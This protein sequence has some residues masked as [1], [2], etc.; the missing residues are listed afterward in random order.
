VTIPARYQF[1]PELWAG[2]LDGT[3]LLHI[4][5]GKSAY[6]TQISL[7]ALSSFFGGGAGGPFLALAGG[8]LGVGGAGQLT[9]TPGATTSIAPVLST[10]SSAGIQFNGGATGVSIVGGGP[11]TANNGVAISRGLAPAGVALSPLVNWSITPSGSTTTLSPTLINWTVPGDSLAIATPAPGGGVTMFNLLYQFGNST[12]TG[13]R[14]GATFKTTQVIQSGNHAGD[15]NAGIGSAGAFY[16]AVQFAHQQ[17]VT[18]GGTSTGQ[19][20]SY[21]QLFAGGSIIRTL[22]LAINLHE[23][24]NW[25][26]DMNT[27]APSFKKFGIKVSQLAT[28]VAQGVLDGAYV[29]ENGGTATNNG[30]HTG[31]LA[32]QPSANFPYASDGTILSAP[33]AADFNTNNT[34]L[35]G[36]DIHEPLFTAHAFR[37]RGFSVDGAGN[38]NVGNGYLAS[39]A[40]GASLDASGSV[41]PAEGTT[42]SGAALVSGGTAGR[43][44]GPMYDGNGG[45]YNITGATAGVVTQ[46]TVVRTPYFASSTPPAN[47]V[48]LS[49]GLANFGNT[50]G[51]VQINIPWTQ[52]NAVALCGATSKLGIFG[53]TP[54]VKDTG[55]AAMTGTPDKASTFATSSVTL[56]QLAGRVMQMQATLTAYG[57]AGP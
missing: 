50:T 16:Q 53:A 2:P 15:P 17:N 32:V 8:T 28:D 18:E 54:V 56:A 42:I 5:T 33:L 40:S 24:S 44:G 35:N 29:V 48:T 10:N 25:E 45:V 19:L 30:W 55:W 1:P 22:A 3:E 49:D 57:L 7:A 12:M 4:D 20:G 27:A 52:P 11:L 6:D 39:T 34:M 9:L 47:P 46:L 51:T 38:L 43:N 37:S 36:I 14:V 13:S 21:G 41:G 26:F 31:F 23:V